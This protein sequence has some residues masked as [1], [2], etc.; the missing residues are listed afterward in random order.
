MSHE[1]TGIPPPKKKNRNFFCDF[2]DEGKRRAV[3][4][5]VNHEAA[6]MPLTVELPA[7]RN[8][9]DSDSDYSM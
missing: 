9:S 6:M 2:G 3:I 4:K 5:V 1:S 8:D 7:V